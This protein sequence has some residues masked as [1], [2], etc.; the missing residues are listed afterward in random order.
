MSITIELSKEEHEKLEA[1]AKSRG[2]S[3]EQC[4][5]DF[6]AASVPGGGGWEHPEKASAPKASP[7]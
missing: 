1:L 2:R 5:R 6:I 7:P 3:A 4:V